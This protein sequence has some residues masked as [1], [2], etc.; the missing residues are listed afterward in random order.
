MET[1]LMPGKSGIDVLED[2]KG[3][4]ETN[5]IPAIMVTALT[6]TQ[7]EKR[8]MNSGALDYIT[9][10]CAH[11]HLEDRIRI[12]VPEFAEGGGSQ[13]GVIKG[14]AAG[15]IA[16]AVPQRAS[17]LPAPISTGSDDIDK[18]LLAESPWDH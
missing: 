7:D 6:G 2:L 3:N 1:E 9:K 4:K 13:K 5:G 11:G 17:A 12:S 10:P 15:K 14:P 16:A 18:A 8:S